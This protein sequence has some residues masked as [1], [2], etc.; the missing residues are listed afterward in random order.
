M[1][2]VPVDPKNISIHATRHAHCKAMKIV[3][4]FMKS[5]HEA[6]QLKFE[7]GEYRNVMSAQST[8]IKAIRKMRVDCKATIRLGK[9]YLIKGGV[10]ND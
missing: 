2:L 10:N 7:P 9:L 8:F 5:E 4:E 6:V 3:E 1:I